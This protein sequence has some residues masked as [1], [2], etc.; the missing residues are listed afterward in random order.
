MKKSQRNAKRRSR[1]I[2]KC[3]VEIGNEY[4]VEISGTTPLG[5]GM[6]RINGFLVLINNT[7]PGDHVR[8]AITKTD[9]INAE[10]EVI[11][12]IQ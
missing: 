1:N 9:P 10:A 11:K 3:P 4:E 2:R 6:A 7:N 8:V 12:N 5:V